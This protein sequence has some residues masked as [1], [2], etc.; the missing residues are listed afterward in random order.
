MLRS[1]SAKSKFFKDLITQSR[2]CALLIYWG[3]LLALGCE[4]SE[5]P[6]S[7]CTL[8]SD[9]PSPRLCIEGGCVLECVESRDCA[10]GLECNEGRCIESSS[11]AD[12]D[13]PSSND[14]CYA[15]PDCE[16]GHTCLNG[17]CVALEGFCERN[18]DCLNGQL[19]S[20]ETRR[21]EESDLPSICS[22]SG[23][24]F[25]GEVCDSGRC[26]PDPCL[27]GACEVS[28]VRDTDCV[29]SEICEMN[30]CVLGCSASR[31]CSDNE[32]CRS[33]RCVPEC[34]DQM[35]CDGGMICETG[36][37]VPEC[38]DHRDCPEGDYCLKGRC[39]IECEIDL[40]CEGEL[41]CR[42]FYCVPQCLSESDCE[43]PFVCQAGECT[44]ECLLD[45][46]CT[47]AARC[48]EGLCQIQD[49]PYSGT[50][51]LSSATPI[52]R[53]NETV[54]IN[55][56]PRIVQATQDNEAFT[57]IFA[58]P[59]TSYVGQIRSGHFTVSWS[60]PNGATAQCGSVN[61]SNSYTATFSTPDLFQGT[62]SVQFFF[63]IPTC[64]CQITWPILGTRQ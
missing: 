19:C 22:T 28:C 27:D 5:T 45:S 11:D 60:G 53:C 42:D 57:L 54:S 29:G 47:G 14:E 49:N 31:P 35:D 4:D 39:G 63:Q 24:C 20:R 55:Y 1:E 48:Q 9:C 34:L 23:D 18:S 38:V 62:L 17:R 16:V 32:I 46:D 26:L 21:C 25:A 6:K 40:D 2:L 61:T 8:N 41:V 13:M 50:F 51:L 58:N 10:D 52:I 7:R 36:R 56:D 59:P 3:A 33:G 12:I 37:C 30:I 15:D 44:P 64:D 43:S